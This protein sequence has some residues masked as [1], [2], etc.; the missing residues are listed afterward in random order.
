MP[1]VG[2]TCKCALFQDRLIFRV[3]QNMHFG[4]Q[5]F[6]GPLEIAG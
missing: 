2:Q 6:S 4:F 3:L 1:G 5:D